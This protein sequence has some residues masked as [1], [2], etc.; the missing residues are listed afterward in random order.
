M[1]VEEYKEMY[2]EVRRTSS[3]KRPVPPW[4]SSGA[5]CRSRGPPPAS[6][7]PL[8][9]YSSPAAHRITPHNLTRPLDFPLST[10]ILVE[11]PPP[12]Y[13]Q[14]LDWVSGHHMTCISHLHHRGHTLT[15]LQESTCLRSTDMHQ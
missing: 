15:L 2:I 9:A 11:Q 1:F 3:N 7:S 8:G 13:A 10:Y 6:S 14:R 5:M 4:R 12:Q